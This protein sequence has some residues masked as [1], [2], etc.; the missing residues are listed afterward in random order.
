MSNRAV[1]HSTSSLQEHARTRDCQLPISC[2][3]TPLQSL[4]QLLKEI[5]SEAKRG[6]IDIDEPVYERAGRDPTTPIVYAGNLEAE[7]AFFGRDL[8][9]D[10][11]LN[12]EPRSLPKKAT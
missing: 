6:A 10:E 9:R 2:W 8:G 12:A 11:V 1:P 3:R 7:V 5:E 4:G